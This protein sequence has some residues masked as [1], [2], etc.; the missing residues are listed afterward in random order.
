MTATALR[1]N[2]KRREGHRGH[3]LDKLPRSAHIGAM[4]TSKREFCRWSPGWA[5]SRAAVRASRQCRTTTLALLVLFAAWPGAAAERRAWAT[6]TNCQY[7]ATKDGDGDSFR[8]RSGTN[9][10][11]VRLYFVDTPEPNLRYAERNR[12]QAEHFGITL[13]E[14]VRAGVKAKE[15]TR[16]LLREPF[17]VRTRWASAAGGGREPRYYSFVEVGTNSLATLLVAQG[18]ARTKGV[19]ATL[20]G[21]PSKDFAARLRSLEAEARAKRLGIWKGSTEKKTEP[22]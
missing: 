1:S 12:E 22:E 5:A 9:E 8:V 11:N 4:L 18:W 16:E 17:T 7:V 6:F 14:T 3:T 15:V 20:P 2:H 21:Q 13:D 10:F 19:T